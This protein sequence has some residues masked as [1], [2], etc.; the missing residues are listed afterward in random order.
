MTKYDVYTEVVYKEKDNGACNWIG[1]VYNRVG[2]S[3]ILETYD[4][5]APSREAALVA[6]K[7][8]SDEIY[9]SATEI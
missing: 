4:G 3:K 8:W 6:A 1:R 2:P 9:S 7:D 5:I